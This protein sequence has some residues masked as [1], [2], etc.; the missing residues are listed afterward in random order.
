MHSHAKDAAAL[1]SF[2]LSLPGAREDFPW[3]ERVAKVGKKVFVFLGRDDKDRKSTSAKQRE[4]MGQP[5]NLVISVKLP[6]S[7]KAVLARSHTKPTD[8]GL[9]AR[10]WVT[11]CFAAGESA[12][13]EQLRKWIE[14]SYRAVAPKKMVQ[15]LAERRARPQNGRDG[16]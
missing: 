8:Y 10:G 1:V 2:A 16:S 15:L 9:G 6:Q 5:G 11:L 12:P 7:G 14:E 3:S 4:H 13:I